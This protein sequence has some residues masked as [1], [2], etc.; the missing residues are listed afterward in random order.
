MTPGVGDIHEVEQEASQP[1]QPI[2]MGSHIDDTD[3]AVQE[4]ISPI[5]MF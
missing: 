3:H 1:S 5:Q 4:D 2:L